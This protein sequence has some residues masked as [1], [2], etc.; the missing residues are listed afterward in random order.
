MTLQTSACLRRMIDA[1]GLADYLN[2]SNRFVVY[3]CG[4]QLVLQIL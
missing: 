2:P 4:E 3:T 1:A